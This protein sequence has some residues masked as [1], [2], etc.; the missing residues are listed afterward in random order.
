MTYNKKKLL[1]MLSTAPLYEGV[2]FHEGR[3]DEFFDSMDDNFCNLYDYA[4]GATKLALIPVNEEEDYVIKIPYT[5]SYNFEDSFYTSS[6]FFPAQEDYWRYCY[7]EN[8]EREWDYCESEMNR[9]QIAAERGFSKC[10]AKTELLGYIN[11]YPIYI[12]EKCITFSSCKIKHV[13]SKEEK[14]KTSNCCNYYSINEDWLTDFRLYYGEAMLLEFIDFIREFGWDD[15]LRD[16]NIGYI[17]D[18]PVL[19]DYSGFLE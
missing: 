8:S 3:N 16:E 2:A 5:G 9:Y 19:I 17:K 13:H 10:F 6:L 15:D 14:S 18:R 12:Q 4:Y 7:A 11:N 1:K